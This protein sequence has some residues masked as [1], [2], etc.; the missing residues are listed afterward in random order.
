MHL[1]Y[2]L[3]EK[4]DRV[5]TMKVLY[6]GVMMWRLQMMVDD[7]APRFWVLGHSHGTA[8]AFPGQRETAVSFRATS[9]LTPCFFR[10]ADAE[11]NAW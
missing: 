9:S 11:R 5:Y 2:Y 8:A 4:G 3:D 1:M 10:L 7:G 6:D